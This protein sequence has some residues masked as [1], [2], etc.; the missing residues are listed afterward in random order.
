MKNIAILSATLLTL[1]STTVLAHGYD[2]HN[3]AES[4]SESRADSHAESRATVSGS[5]DSSNTVT[6]D[7]RRNPVSTA[8]AAPLVATDDSCQGSVSGGTQFM[9]FG[10][11]LGATHSVDDCFRLKYGRELDRRGDRD[12]ATA[13]Y[14]QNPMVAQAMA[15]AGQPCPARVGEGKPVAAAY[16][17]ASK[18]INQ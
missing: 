8:Y 7:D 12:V 5:G 13:L 18:T 6:Q 9:P 15:D 16:P 14:C 2:N 4:R 3:D 17:T 1:T 10:I 11:S